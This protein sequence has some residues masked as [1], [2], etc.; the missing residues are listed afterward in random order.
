[1]TPRLWMNGSIA[2]EEHEDDTENDAKT[3][4]RTI[5]L[6]WL[7]KNEPNGMFHLAG[8]L[9]SGKSTE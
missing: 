6:T 7:E 5:F 1:M 9:G 3:R 4:A 2:K 8:K